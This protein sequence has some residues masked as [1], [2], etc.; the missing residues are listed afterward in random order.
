MNNICKIKWAAALACGMVVSEVSALTVTTV[1]Q[2]TRPSSSTYGA[3]QIS[4]ITYAGGDLFYAVDDNDNKLYPLTL[5]INRANGSLTTSGITIGT[6]VVMS[7]GNDMEGC[8]FDPCSGKVWISQETNALIREF[9][10]ATGELTRSAPV[11]A[12]QKKYNGNYSL[13]ALTISGDGKTMWTA[14]EEALKV[15]GLL[16]TNSVGSVIRLTK[17]TRES[18]YDNWMP[19][20]EWAYVTQPIG[21][22]KDSNTRSGVS[23]LCALPDG[24]LLVLERRCYQGGLFPDFN[25]RIY[26]VNFSGATDVSSIAALKD[27]SYTA[28]TKTMLWQYTHSNDMPNYEGICL[29]PR[30]NDGSCTL[31]LVGDGGSYAEEGIFVLKLTGLNIWT[32]Y[33]DAFVDNMYMPSIAGYNYRYVDGSQV[34]VA[35]SKESAPASGEPASETVE[36]MSWAVTNKQNQV[37]ASGVGYVASFTVTN[38]SWLSWKTGAA[39][40]PSPIV[41]SDSFEAY[42]VGTQGNTLPGWTGEDAEIIATNYSTTAGFPLAAETHTKVLSVDGELARAYPEVETNALQK[43]DFMVAV[44]RAARELSNPTGDR[45]KIVVACN[46]NGYMRAMCKVPN[47]TINWVELSSTQY[48]NDDW[49][50]VELLFDYTSNNDGRA[51]VQ[52]KLDG[53]ECATGSGYASPTDL[54]TGGSWYELMDVG[55]KR[56]VSSFVASGMCKLDDVAMTIEERPGVAVMFADDGAE[57]LLESGTTVTAADVAAYVNGVGGGAVTAITKPMVL[58][59]VLGASKVLT[60]TSEDSVLTISSIKQ[61]EDGWE[62]TVSTSLSPED[63]AAGATIDLNHING[64]L[65]VVATDALGK[66]FEPVDASKFEVN[67]STDNS[68]DAVIKV[69]DES[70]KFLK[71]T[72]VR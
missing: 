54:T 67:P 4:G 43:L 49:V 27:A 3:E 64:V 13:E 22:A 18:V 52:I 53:T 19:N 29:G 50:R 58:S 2:V 69:T 56:C 15:D 23:G 65:K 39:A 25:I 34:T 61:V 55:S 8:A 31:V 44:R 33:I 62:I 40:Q 5:A 68:R 37:L 11:P 21:T 26:Q 57:S 28:T 32:M 48:A 17:L 38:D 16:A 6:G 24:T 1:S 35:L 60:T 12:V 20:G 63:A 7:D 30:L 45:N 36:Q 71:A 59:Y 9:D 66:K 51:F 72:V 14:N 41:G 42:A 70:A 46:S 10:P 47:G